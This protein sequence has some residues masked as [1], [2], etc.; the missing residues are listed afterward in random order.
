M[1]TRIHYWTKDVEKVI[2]CYVG[3]FGFELVYRQPSE[4]AADFC[5]LEMKGSQVMFAANPVL[6]PGSRPD[7]DLLREVSNRIDKP[8]PISV[9]IG[10]DNVDSHYESVTGKGAKV[11][12][13]LWNTPW[14]LKQFSVLDP[15]N[16]LTTFFGE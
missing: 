12:E 11:V 6:D 2:S 13:P 14:D 9:Y 3:I 7:Q 16:N 1:S 10:V 4:G 5:I 8:G 15:D